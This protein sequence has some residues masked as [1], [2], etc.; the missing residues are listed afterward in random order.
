M[1]RHPPLDYHEPTGRSG[2]DPGGSQRRIAS[3]MPT[4][5]NIETR[6]PLV[7]DLDGTLT[8]ADTLC[9]SFTALALRRPVAAISSLFVLSRGRAAFKRHVAQLGE[10]DVAALPYRRELLDLAASEKARGRPVHLI[11]AS[12]QRVADAVAATLGVFDGATGSD[13]INNLK[14]EAKLEHLR[15]RFPDGFIYAG[16]AAADLPVFRAARGVILCDG[17]R[18]RRHAGSCRA[19][20]AAGS[21]ESDAA[22]AAPTSMVEES[23]DL[24]AAVRRPRL[25]RS[26]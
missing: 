8:P 19:A 10:P 9:E 24:R 1:A 11:T 17:G 14:G 4:V 2:A 3:R 18:C 20:I 16:D 12:D 13:G 5:L 6:I 21:L 23:A 25:W 7:L 26:G 22:R 15:G